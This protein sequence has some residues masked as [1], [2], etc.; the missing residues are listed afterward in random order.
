[1]QFKNK[2]VLIQ[3]GSGVLEQ[4]KNLAQNL[5]SEQYSRHLELLGGNTIGKHYRHI[6]ECYQCMLNAKD[7]INYDKRQRD[8]ELEINNRAAATVLQDIIIHLNS[9]ENIDLAYTYEADFSDSG[10]AP[11]SVATTIGRELAYNI[12]H[13]VHHMAIIQM[14]TKYYFPGTVLEPNFGVAAST[15]RYQQEICAQ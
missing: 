1:M 10:P 12:E 13:A 3:A 6:I 15:R 9:I 5:T 4:L 11:V 8:P 14:V 2:E 7:C